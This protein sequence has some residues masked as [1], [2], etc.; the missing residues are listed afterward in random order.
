[1]T[2]VSFNGILAV[3]GRRDKLLSISDRNDRITPGICVPMVTKGGDSMLLDFGSPG[4][5]LRCLCERAAEWLT[6]TRGYLPVG[7]RVIRSGRT[8]CWLTGLL[9]RSAMFCWMGICGLRCV[10][11]VL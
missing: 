2:S 6:E 11:G 1:M 5:V 4:N 8:G 10:V 7:V 9:R 3:G